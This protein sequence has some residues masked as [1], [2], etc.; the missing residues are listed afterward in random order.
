VADVVRRVLVTFGGADPADVTSRLLPVFAAVHAERAIEFEVVIGGASRRAADFDQVAVAGVQLVRDARDMA[1][2]MARADVA[3]ASAGTTAWE[4]C[5]L[6]VP[7]MLVVVAEN[8]RSVADALVRHHAA[9]SLGPADALDPGN[10][11]SALGALLD[12][13]E[14][15]AGLAARAR[16]I[17]DGDGVRRVRMHLI[18]DI[19]W[20]RRARAEDRQAIWEISNEPDVRAASFSPA[21]IP[22]D[23][24]VAWFAA[25]LADPAHHI[26][27]AVDADEHVIGQVR[28]RSTGEEATASISLRHGARGRGIGARLLGESARELV[29]T[30]PVRRVV[31]EIKRDNEASRRAFVRAGY[32]PLASAAPDAVVTRLVFEA[33]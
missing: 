9:V 29:G 31:A 4:L 20:I 18:G 8:Q 25:A 2:R 12:S 10:V 16:E 32:T 15:R 21:P 6:G 28:Y 1:A 11:A 27:V 30:S 24:H 5:L 3:I 7:S 26:Y 19:F 13:R 14:R 23:E 17:V 22:W 33:K